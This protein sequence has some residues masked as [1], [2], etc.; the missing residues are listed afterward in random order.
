MRKSRFF[1]LLLV[2]G[3]GNKP[4]PGKGYDV[5]L[6][7]TIVNNSSALLQ[8]TLAFAL[9]E[10][11][12]CSNGAENGN[13]VAY[14]VSAGATD[15]HSVSQTCS[16]PLEKHVGLTIDRAESELFTWTTNA[17]DSPTHSLTVV[18]DDRGCVKQ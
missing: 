7:A 15:T 16:L 18:C 12:R 3:C 13:Q 8:G 5:T 4:I 11:D 2:A 6:T 1:F 9:G 10:E 17:V 14:A